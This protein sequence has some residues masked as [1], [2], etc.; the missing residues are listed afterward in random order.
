M[1]RRA[2][3]MD[4][5]V[6]ATDTAAPDRMSLA[7][8]VAARIPHLVVS[9]TPRGAAV[10]PFV[11]PGRTSC[12]RCADLWLCERDQDWP[13]VVAQLERALLVPSHAAASWAAGTA[14]L[15]IA[16]WLRSGSAPSEDAVWEVVGATQEARR[17]PRHPDCG[18]REQPAEEEDLAV[19]QVA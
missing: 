8:L 7:D 2:R 5:V 19:T 12:V 9:P 3:R 11:D 17:W 4:V 16:A 13:A 10:G 15:H 6:W 18:C 1:R 14:A